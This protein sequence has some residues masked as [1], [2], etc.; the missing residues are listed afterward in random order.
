MNY[1]NTNR[2]QIWRSENKQSPTDRDFQGTI[3]IDGTEYWLSGW[4]RKPTDDPNAPVVSLKAKLKEAR[5]LP[6]ERPETPED[7]E[8]DEIPF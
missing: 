4:K 5:A 1:D 2:G 6:T 7:W 3:N 8:D